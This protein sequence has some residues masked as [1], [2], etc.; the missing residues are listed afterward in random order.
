MPEPR[1]L[2]YG[3]EMISIK[4]ESHRLRMEEQKEGKSWGLSGY[5]EIIKYPDF[6]G[7]SG[8]HSGFMFVAECIRYR[9]NNFMLS[10]Q[11]YL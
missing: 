2:T 11:C 6:L 4:T 3:Q 10:S 1:Q 5:H 9:K 8:F 7:H